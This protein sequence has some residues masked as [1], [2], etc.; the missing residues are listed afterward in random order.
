MIDNVIQ[1]PFFTFADT[2]L[3]SKIIFFRKKLA[4]QSGS[5]FDTIHSCNC[6]VASFSQSCSTHPTTATV[7]QHSP[8]TML[9][10]F[11]FTAVTGF[12]TIYCILGAPG[13]SD[14]H[15]YQKKSE[16]QKSGHG[17]WCDERPIP[18]SSMTGCKSSVRCLLLRDA[19]VKNPVWKFWR[20]AYKFWSF[21][22]P[23]AHKACRRQFPQSVL[24][25]ASLVLLCEIQD[26]VWISTL[27]PS[28]NW[29]G[30]ADVICYV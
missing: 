22:Q 10:V 17:S 2:K 23:L 7:I 20:S 8:L 28:R 5:T 25:P 29:K 6:P 15:G 12:R 14:M 13:S 27:L 11:T 9:R 1:W 3:I 4:L 24:L 18:L 21:I 19:G 16:H 30:W 26:E